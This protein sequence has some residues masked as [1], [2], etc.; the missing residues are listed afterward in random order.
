MSILDLL[1][2]R[3]MEHFKDKIS[4]SDSK[5]GT[6][7]IVNHDGNSFFRSFMLALIE[8]YILKGKTL[9]LMEICIDIESVIYNKFTKFDSH[10]DKLSLQV[11]LGKIITNL[12]KGNTKEAYDIF[13][14][15]Y[16]IDNNW[17]L[18][19]I[20]Y[21]KSVMLEYININSDKNKFTTLLAKCMNPMYIDKKSKLIFNFYRH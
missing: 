16:F 8:Y 17:D 6:V 13:L 18:G 11:I 9:E 2:K 12:E 14:K 1:D 7:R 19:L 21:M 4:F 15:A 3:G 10:V 20:K 5:I